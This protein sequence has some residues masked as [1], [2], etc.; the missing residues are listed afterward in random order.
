MINPFALFRFC[1]VAP[2]VLIAGS[3]AYSIFAE[4]TFSQ[5][6]RD[7]LTWNGDGAMIDLNTEVWS[8]GVIVF[9]A[10][11]GLVMLLALI[12]QVLFFFYWRPSRRLY[13]LLC[14]ISY[15]MAFFFGLTILTPVEYVLLETATFL[16]GMSLALAY[17][18][19]VA[20]R[21]SKPLPPPLPE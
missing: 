5:Q 11:C 7:I 8:A 15:P 13:L 1:V 12:N 20:A 9:A 6:W 18:S 17:Y 14:F 4:A 10:L 2:L 3:V 16:S 19:P 21:F